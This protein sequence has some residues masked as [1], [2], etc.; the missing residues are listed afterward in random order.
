[1]GESISRNSPAITNGSPSDGCI[2]IRYRP[3]TRASS[4]TS[5]A[6]N[7]LGPNQRASSCGSTKLLN[8]RSGDAGTSRSMCSVSSR[9]SVAMSASE[10][11]FRRALC[12][13]VTAPGRCAWWFEAGGH[14]PTVDRGERDLAPTLHTRDRPRGVVAREEADGSGLERMSAQFA[15]EHAA[16]EQQRVQRE[17]YEPEAEPVEHADERDRL[18]FD[19]GLLVHLLHRDLTRR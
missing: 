7:P 1:M 15:A 19:P 10:L 5:R 18:D 3:P 17:R 14:R 8:T 12:V 13:H 16:V 2:V 6:V 4:C 11:R 9:G